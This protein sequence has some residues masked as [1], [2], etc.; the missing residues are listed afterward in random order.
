MEISSNESSSEK[1]LILTD[2]TARKQ[3]EK[4]LQE[5]EF[6]LSETQR[7]GLIGSYSLDIV[8]DE[9][10]S[11]TVLYQIFGLDSDNDSDKS[12]AK[13][14]KRIHPEDHDE[15]LDYFSKEYSIKTA[16]IFSI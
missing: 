13:W 10:I 8:A 15:L 12:T 16:I 7:V 1:R 11:S 2:I 9:W 5:R 6:W 4:K 3:I 14:I